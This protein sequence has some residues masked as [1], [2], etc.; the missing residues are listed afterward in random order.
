MPEETNQYLTVK[1]VAARYRVCVMTVHNWIKR[2][3]LPCYRFMNTIRISEDN[4][5]EFER[6]S[7]CDI[8]SEKQKEAIGKQPGQ[9]QK[10]NPNAILSALK[11]KGWRKSA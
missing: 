11:T 7:L 1:E 3:Q 8:T 5:I 2:K 10:G 9:K 4:L 6:G